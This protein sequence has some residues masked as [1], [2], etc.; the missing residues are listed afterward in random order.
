MLAATLGAL[1]VSGVRRRDRLAAGL[2]ALGLVGLIPFSLSWLGAEHVLAY[3]LGAGVLLV[4][5]RR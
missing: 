3:V 4:A 1:L 2:G 5:P